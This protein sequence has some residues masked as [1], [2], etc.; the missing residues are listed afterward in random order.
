MRRLAPRW[1]APLLAAPLVLA[2]CGTEKSE[3]TGPNEQVAAPPAARAEDPPEPLPALRT[4]TLAPVEHAELKG[5]IAGW[6]VEGE[7]EYVEVKL[8][9]VGDDL[10]LDWDRLHVELDG[11]GPGHVAVLANG[12]GASEAQVLVRRPK[13]AAAP[14]TLRG[15]LFARRW[16]DGRNEWVRVPFAGAGG[17]KPADDATLQARWADALARVLGDTWTEPHPWKQFAAGR[18]AIWLKKQPGAKAIAGSDLLRDRPART[19]LSQLMDTTTGVMSMQEALQ[20]DRGLRLS[21]ETGP[22]TV[23]L[24]D[25]KPP[26]LAAH[27]FAA[28]QA[29]LPNPNGGAAEPLAAA[30]PAEFWYARVDDVRL[31]LR[32]LDE[33]DTWITPVVQILQQNPEDRSLTARYQRQLGLRRSDLAKLFGHTVVGEVAIVGSDPYL[34]EGS[35]VTLIFALKQPE[36][37]DAELARQ[38]DSYRG[39]ITGLEASTVKLA[40]VDVQRAADP[41]GQVRQ[42]RA[43]VGDLAFVSNSPGALA[44]VLAAAQG[45]APRLADEP[46]LKYMLARDPGTHQALAFL[47]DKFIAAVVAPQQKIQAARRQEALAE[48]LV[49]GYAALLHGWLF[50]HA[51]KDTQEMIAAGLLAADELKHAG[52]E[53]IAFAP[54]QAARSSWGSPE[55]LTPLVDLPA[56]EKVSEVERVAYD[57]FALGYQNYWRQFIDPVAI[58]LDVRDDAAGAVA[59]VD[60]RVL[61]L[62]SATNYSEIEGVVGKSRVTVTA[63]ERGL[64]AVWAVGQ[65]SALRRDMDQLMRTLT[66]KGDVG[67]GWLGDWVML[68]LDDRAGVVGL[69]SQWDDAAQLPPKRER[70]QLEDLELWEQVGKFPGYAIAEVKNPT[71]LVATLAAIKT[72]VESVAPGMVAWGEVARHRDLPIVRVGVNPG[73]PL[74]PDKAIAEAFGIHYVQTGAAIVVGL[75]RPTVTRVIDDLLDGRLP[76]A[77]TA[78]D[79][80]FVVQT[81][82]AVGAPLWTAL[83]WMLQGQANTAGKSALRSAEILLRG[84]PAATQSA[85]GLARLGLQ[86]FGFAPLNAHGTPEFTLRPE[87]A[88]DPLQGSAIAPTFPPLPIA[89]SPIERLMQRLTAVRG[90]VAFD[91]EPEAA[92][93]DARS[94]HTKFSIHL[95]PAPN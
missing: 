63:T 29:S 93:A 52:G 48:L 49:P 87:G 64:Q 25:L 72:T 41:A 70:N 12:T 85:E 24:A 3:K 31:L 78:T 23:A 37:F 27:P 79:P 28:M 39:E 19:D 30:T 94:L 15:A 44:R 71:T 38:L 62:I 92:G 10:S 51:P 77:G 46:D 68:G 9:I 88:A 32:L 21:R 83:L 53:A 33:A 95:G 74:L 8:P 17:A 20:H 45:Q 35:D 43:R 22:R 7:V 73:A 4:G 60:V 81:R 56:V 86:Y 34:R 82:S 91:K 13:S 80:Q 55:A 84:D 26:P 14:E 47:S 36:V 69:L 67:L 5:A 2:G 50:G 59:D 89:G 90:E 11:A 1:F 54:G 66:G 75:D 42:H 65:D 61:P 6:R 18:L 57:N 58:R 76:K 16:Q 40:G